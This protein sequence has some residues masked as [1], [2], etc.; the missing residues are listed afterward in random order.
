M[1]HPLSDCVASPSLASREGDDAL[2]ARRLLLGVSGLNHASRMV[3]LFGGLG[4]RVVNTFMGSASAAARGR[5]GTPSASSVWLASPSTCT[6]PSGKRR[7]PTES[8]GEAAS[9]PAAAPTAHRGSK[10]HQ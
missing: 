10:P 3:R 7:A 9:A 2:A 4:M 8:G 1:K 5:S 6:T